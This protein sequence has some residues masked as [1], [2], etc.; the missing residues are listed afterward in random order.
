MHKCLPTGILKKYI[1]MNK[2]N[3]LNILPSQSSVRLS[4]SLTRSMPLEQGHCFA[5]QVVVQVKVKQGYESIRAG[6]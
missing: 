1:I 5:L 6:K 2:I 4:Q 3:V